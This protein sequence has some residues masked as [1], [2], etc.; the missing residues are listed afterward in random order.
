MKDSKVGLIA[1]SFD[2]ITRGHTDVIRKALRTLDMLWVAV[3]S[4]SD[5]PNTYFSKADR[6]DMTYAALQIELTPAEFAKI[7]VV[8]MEKAFTVDVC[9]EVGATIYVRGLR[10]TNDFV[11]EQGMQQF[12]EA[13][14]PHI[15]TMFVMPSAE[16]ARI[17]SS[18]IKGMVGLDRWRDRVEPYIHPL[19]M[20]HFNKKQLIIEQ[21]YTVIN[22]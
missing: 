6:W 5:K 16:K 19:T 17:S 20:E 2:P 1:G 13:L 18:A 14:A 3:T 22:R 12:N 7:D 11:Y 4:N 21:G 8:T 9:N 15:T 10:N